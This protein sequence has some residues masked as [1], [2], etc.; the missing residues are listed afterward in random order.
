M[1]K[2]IKNFVFNVS[3][4]AALCHLLGGKRWYSLNRSQKMYLIETY[5]LLLKHNL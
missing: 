3:I 4:Y 2:T 5:K 1:K